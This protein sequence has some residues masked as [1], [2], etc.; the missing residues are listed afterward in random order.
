[1]LRTKRTSMRA[2]RVGAC[3][4]LLAV[5]SVHE[6]GAAGS[7]A[8]SVSASVLSKNVCRFQTTGPTALPFGAIDPAGTN[9]VTVNLTLQ[10]RCNG[11]DAIAAWSV[12][13]DD[14]LYEAGAGQ[15]RMRH[16]TVLSAFLP[17]SLTFPAAGT[18]ARNTITNMSI[19]ATL[20]PASYANAQV[21][22]YADSVV[23][24]ITP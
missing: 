24:T 15:P 3:I 12:A 16:A 5:A 20:S 11:S 2:A 19:S 23:L 9:P 1:M 13:S 7:H 14:G 8:L 6:A 4:A 22:A 17:Y 21:G 18:V 10:Y